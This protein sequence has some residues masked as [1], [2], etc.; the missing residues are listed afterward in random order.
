MLQISFSFIHFIVCI[1]HTTN[2]PDLGDIFS[3][4]LTFHS[5]TSSFPI[6]F[7]V[8]ILSPFIF[9]HLVHFSFIPI[10]L[11]SFSIHLHPFFVYSNSRIIFSFIFMLFSFI[12]HVCHPISLVSTYIHVSVVFQR[13]QDLRERLLGG[14]PPGPG[15]ADD[16]PEE[17]EAADG[18]H[19]LGGGSR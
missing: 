16:H 6:M 7:S 9:V 19:R 5:F 4:V 10:P 17:A 14:H 8:F 18:H 2:F 11:H 13:H 12:L 1:Q 15:A 3:F